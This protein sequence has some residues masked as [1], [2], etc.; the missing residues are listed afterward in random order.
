MKPQRYTAEQVKEIVDRITTRV[1][2]KKLRP[3]QS[4]FA[5]LTNREQQ[6]AALV[7]RG[8]TNKEIAQHL[9]LS[10][11]TVKVH[12]HHI[13]RKLGVKTRAALIYTLAH[14]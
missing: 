8:H 13:F 6:V 9:G 10:E 1:L 2:E 14:R 11:G 3:R 7:S 5:G 4:S 12:A